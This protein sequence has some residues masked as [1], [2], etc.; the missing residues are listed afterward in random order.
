MAE[1]AGLTFISDEDVE[2]SDFHYDVFEHLE[3]LSLLTSS[4]WGAQPLESKKLEVLICELTE[5]PAKHGTMGRDEETG[6]PLLW[7]NV[8]WSAVQQRAEE[9]AE[10]KDDEE[11]VA[12]LTG[13]NIFFDVLNHFSGK[14]WD[15]KDISD[16]REVIADEEF[17][18][19]LELTPFVPNADGSMRAI[20]MLVGTRWGFSLSFQVFNSDEECVFLEMEHLETDQVYGELE[21]FEEGKNGLRWAGEDTL[22]FKSG[23]FEDEV[24]VDLHSD[25]EDED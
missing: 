20:A 14:E 22:M 18:A 9:A 10:D 8:Q 1:F 4:L 11:E 23:A 17:E 15:A 5:D 12:I 6:E 3:H 2:W 13:E 16:L 25:E 24:A 7:W 21:W 19:L